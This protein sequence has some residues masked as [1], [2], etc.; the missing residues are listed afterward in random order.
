MV[1]CLR[2]SRSCS[3]DGQCPLQPSKISLWF[4]M[5]IPSFCVPHN[6]LRR[7]GGCPE[8]MSSH[9]PRRL[10]PVM[11]RA[12]IW[13]PSP[14]PWV[15]QILTSKLIPG[16][17]RGAGE[18]GLSPHPWWHG[19]LASSSPVLFP[20]H[21]PPPPPTLLTSPGSTSFI[22]PWPQILTSGL[23]SGELDAP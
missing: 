15:G 20:N 14:L 17:S 2:S 12:A 23:A 11:M 22:N 16:A 6:F 4:F 9:S 3:R 1:K 8:S 18:P 7:T 21:P 10:W 5:L 13:K 19:S